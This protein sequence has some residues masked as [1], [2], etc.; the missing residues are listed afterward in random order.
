[1]ERGTSPRNCSKSRK[2][3]SKSIS[4]IVSW[5]CGKKGHLMKYCKPQ[6]GKEGD[7]LEDNNHEVNVTCDV[8]QDDLIISLENIIDSWVVD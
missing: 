3:R 5:K 4:G 7:G 1:M 8:L 2:G 6:K